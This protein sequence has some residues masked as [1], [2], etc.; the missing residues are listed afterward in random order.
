VAAGLAL[1]GQDPVR[2][3]RGGIPNGHDQ[4]VSPRYQNTIPEQSSPLT[5]ENLALRQHLAVLE[6]SVKRP[7][8]RQRERMLAAGQDRIRLT[9]IPISRTI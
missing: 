6:R 8:L 7:K 9:I 1:P 5:A 2:K 4:S 3:A